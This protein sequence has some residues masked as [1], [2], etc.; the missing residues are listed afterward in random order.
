M[1]IALAVEATVH[2]LDLTMDHPHARGP[3]SEELA[4]VRATWTIWCPRPG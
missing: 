3:A 2:H 1:P 4:A